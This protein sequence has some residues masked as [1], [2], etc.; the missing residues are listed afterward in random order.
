MTIVRAR[1]VLPVSQPPLSDGAVAIA[2]GRIRAVGRWSDLRRHGAGSPVDLGESVL[3]PG[4]VNAHCHLDYTAMAGQLAPPQSFS[5][6]IKNIT[7]L[8]GDWSRADFA[9]SWRRGAEMLLQSGTTV[10]GDIESAPDLLP[11][12]WQATALRVFSFIELTGVKSRRPPREILE[13][14]LATIATLPRGRHRA[15]LSPHAPYSTTPELLRRCG[16]AARQRR[17]RLATHVAESDEEYAMFMSRRGPMSAW[18]A[19]NGRDLSDCGG[20]SPVQHLARQRLL[21]DRL[22]AVHANYLAPGDA[23]LLARHGTHVVHCPRSHA[24]FGHRPFPVTALLQRGVNVCL[25]T[26]SLATVQTRQQEPVALDLF[27]EMRAFSQ[28]HPA[29]SPD[30]ILRL[31]T[32]NGARALGLAGRAGEIRPGAWAD[33]I[34][35]PCDS[36]PREAA[37]AL[38]GCSQPVAAVMIGGEWIL[39][40]STSGDRTSTRGKALR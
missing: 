19:R 29:W 15:W 34:A 20:V 6:W 25:G 33:L 27:A 24:Y 11:E 26:D 2:G 40:F 39:G 31:S 36:R 21:S 1:L 8:K 30:A 35:V 7:E 37:A 32:V 17:W 16:A 5:A 12:M 22:L 38:L 10:V 18:L 13:A 9:R 4:L 23:D 14:A 28:T 3:L